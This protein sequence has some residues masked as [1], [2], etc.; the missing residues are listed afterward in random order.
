MLDNILERVDSSV[1]ENKQSLFDPI[2]VVN[3]V[4]SFKEKLMRR[5]VDKEI[6]TQAFE[7]FIYEYLNESFCEIC[8]KEEIL[9]GFIK[10]TIKQIYLDITRYQ[11]YKIPLPT[12][13]IFQISTLLK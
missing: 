12:S 6:L 11:Q 9:I 10:V 8:N 1:R 4:N 5:N 7:D 3:I 2:I 13:F